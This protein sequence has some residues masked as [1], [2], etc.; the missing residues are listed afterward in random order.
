MFLRGGAPG[1]DW[2]YGKLHKNC[3]E[4]SI[5]SNVVKYALKGFFYFVVSRD[6]DYE[7]TAEAFLGAFVMSSENQLGSIGTYGKCFEM[8]KMREGLILKK[9]LRRCKGLEK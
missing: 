2:G 6:R 4:H 1:I 8:A 5:E 3:I 7:C 9:F